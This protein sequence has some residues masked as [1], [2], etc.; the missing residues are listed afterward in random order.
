MSASEGQLMF[1]RPDG[2]QYEPETRFR[3]VDHLRRALVAIGDVVGYDHS[4]RRRK[5]R[6]RRGEPGAPAKSTWR[7]QDAEQRTCPACGMKLWAPAPRS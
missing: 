2:K 6:A 3:L 1:P 4:C 5:A 7:H